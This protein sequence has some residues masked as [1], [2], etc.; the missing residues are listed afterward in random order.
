MK[1]KKLHILLVDNCNCH[2]GIAAMTAWL[3]N[4]MANRGHRVTLCNQKPV[5][6][7]LQPL[8]PLWRAIVKAATDPGVLPPFPRGSHALWELYTLHPDVARMQYNFTD[9][10][11]RIQKFRQRLREL[12]ADVCLPMFGD[13]RQL[14][15]AVTLLGT[16][17]PYLYTELCSPRLMGTLFWSPKGRLAAMSGA[18]RIHL[19]SASHAAHLP[20]FLQ[21]R[22]RCIAN[23]IPDAPGRANVEGYDGQPLK[24]LWLGRFE[25]YKQWKLMML[26]FDDIADRFPQWE[27][28]MVGCGEELAEARRLHEKLHAAKRIILH[29]R[30]EDTSPHYASAQLF[31][32]SSYAEGQPTTLLEAQA[33]GLP[34]VGFEDCDGINSLIQSGHTGELAWPMTAQAL[35]DT[36]AILMAD[37]SLRRRMQDSILAAQHPDRHRQALDAWEELFQETAACK[38][39]TVMDTFSQDPF[40]SQARLSSVA[41]REWLYRDFGNPMPDSIEGWL[42]GVKERIKKYMKNC[43][44]RTYFSR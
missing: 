11:V 35:G 3:A 27:L 28:H 33:W 2:G 14:V 1:T 25:F 12:N 24:L 5:P 36:L 15:W 7:L 41:R 4:G 10:N 6:R 23:P 17:I 18:D 19:L 26:A 31:C 8:H 43:T 21:E 38:G 29:G 32:I 16:G 30:V 22:V 9:K 44:F 20:D 13:S 42:W 34:S 40:A 39:R 37:A